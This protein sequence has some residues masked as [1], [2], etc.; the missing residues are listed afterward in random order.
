MFASRRFLIPA[1]ALVLAALAVRAGEPEM[2][3]LQHKGAVQACAFSPDGKLVAT[4]GADKT[5]RLWD[6][7][8]GRES[9]R[10]DV[11]EKVARVI[12][13][14]DGSRLI[15]VAAEKGGPLQSWD[16]ATG[17]L[18]WKTQAGRG[19]PMSAAISPDGLRL[20]AGSEDR[21]LYVFDAPTG[22]MVMIA[23]GHAGTV[24]A[25]A[26]SPD[27]KLLATGSADNS[28]QVWDQATGRT[29]LSIRGHNKGIECVA[30]SPDGKMLA[31]GGQD[32]VVRVWDPS[33]GKELLKL[34]AQG[35][36]HCVAFSPD[37]KTIAV[38][39]TD[40]AVRL[41]DPTTGKET[42]RF[43]LLQGKIT[44]LAFSPDGKRVVTAGPEDSAIVWDLTRDEKPLPKDLKLSAKEL[45]TLWTDLAGSDGR[46]AY[47]ALRTLRAAPADSVPF[48]RERLKPKPSESDD[49]KITKL[50]ADLDDDNF[51]TRE[52]ATKELE[53]LGKAAEAAVRKAMAG[54]PSAEAKVRLEKLLAKLGGDAALTP[55][56][57]RDLL[58]VRVL[59]TA[60]TPEARKL[61]ETLVSES[62][63][64]WVTKE[65]KSALER[66]NAEK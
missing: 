65:A 49:K 61:L 28:V 51:D 8:S 36:V 52:K 50:I 13:A 22:K 9:K 37:A 26:V 20:A 64:W 40:K 27:G 62:P 24:T 47:T 23:R 44:G 53:D 55:E 21:S 10:L 43:G 5:V 6:V 48:L 29:L 15:T 59:E 32:K 42:R 35:E 34:E 46:K 3:P 60:G 39:G 30:F 54:K 56:Q 16:V 45:D 1:L 14:P 11:G 18:L 2:M 33:T 17:K 12:F 4:G 31:T 63:G 19:T 66:L 25:V 38:A 57:N 58:A 7:N 41:F